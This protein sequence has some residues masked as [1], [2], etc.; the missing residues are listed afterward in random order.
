MAELDQSLAAAKIFSSLETSAGRIVEDV[1][2]QLYGWEQVDSPAHTAKSEI[3]SVRVVG[4]HLELAALKSGP[5]CINDSMVQQISSA[6]GKHSSSWLDEW[7]CHSMTYIVGMN[8]STAKN[9]NKKD[10]RIVYEAQSK[11]VNEGWAISRSC[12]DEESRLAKASCELARD[13]QTIIVIALQGARFWERIAGCQEAVL[14]ISW[15]LSELMGFSQTLDS[16]VK[17]TTDELAPLRDFST[18]FS[19]E[20]AQQARFLSFMIMVRHFYDELKA[21]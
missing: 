1:I 8:Y 10:W 5:S 13:G 2:P 18:E 20:H 7:K 17:L 21:A 9:S 3:D 19:N 15:A 14:D 4:D 12:Y 6:I 16:S 11:L